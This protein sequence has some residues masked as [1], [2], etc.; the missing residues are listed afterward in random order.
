MSAVL[1]AE[2]HPDLAPI[3]DTVLDAVIVMDE[4]GCVI[5]W[6]AI[7]EKVLGWSAEEAVGRQ[8][9]ALVVPSQHRTAHHEGLRRLKGGGEARVLNRLIEITALHRE[10][11]EFPVELSIT[12]ASDRPGSAFVGFL[13]DISDRRKAEQRLKQQAL[14]GRLM[15]EIADMAADADSL[16]IA[17]ERAIAAICE[18]TGW[19][20]GHAFIAPKA[21]GGALS[22]T[23]IW[24][25]AQAGLADGLKAATAA[26][27]FTPGIGLPGRIIQ[28]GEPLWISDTDD[29]DNFP[30]KG[31]GFRGAFGFPLRHE[32]KTIAVLEFFST[33]VSPPD[34]DLLLVVRALGEQVGRVFERKRTDDRQELL[35][36]ELRHRVKNI[37]AVV[38][39]VAHQTFS[40]SGDIGQAQAAFMK[41]LA[42]LASAQDLIASDNWRGTTLREIVAAALAGCGAAAERVSI[43]GPDV[44]IPA[45]TAVSVA[46]AVH[47]LCT[48]AFKYGSLSLDSG[49]VRISWGREADGRHVFEWRELGGPPVQAPTRRGFGTGLIERGLERQLGGKVELDF[50]P[51]GLVCR[52]TADLIKQTASAEQGDQ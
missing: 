43:T 20:V 44:P 36:Q 11:R 42:A 8:L 15:F 50:A 49:R 41:R 25:E 7:A 4:D 10:G 34:D 17:L 39:A 1:P 27:A 19:P 45:A 16:D 26:I 47:E 32:G 5:G 12:R 51:D 22:S 23:S 21:G 33:E 46:L 48:N 3:L 29:D 28:S 18:I 2:F 52:F 37:L 31:H 30:R 24:F 35:V 38:Q 40:R 6:N 14:Q 9:A 13:R